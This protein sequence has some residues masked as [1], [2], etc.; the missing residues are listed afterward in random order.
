MRTEGKLMLCTISELSEFLAGKINGHNVLANAFPDCDF[1]ISILIAI[2]ITKVLSVSF[3]EQMHG[4][5]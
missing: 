3:Q 1:S 2:W 5:A 4:M